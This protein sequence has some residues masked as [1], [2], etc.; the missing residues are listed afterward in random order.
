[1]KGILR[2]TDKAYLSFLL[3]AL[4]SPSKTGLVEFSD[5]ISATKPLESKERAVMAVLIKV[6]FSA[7]TSMGISKVS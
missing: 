2:T 6:D 4:L 7:F 5:V 1:M 3:D